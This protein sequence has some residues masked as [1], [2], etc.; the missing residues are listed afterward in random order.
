MENEYLL[1][2]GSPEE[3]RVSHP[4]NMKEFQ[5]PLRYQNLQMPESLT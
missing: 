4:Q 5:D 1:K 2:S 3:D